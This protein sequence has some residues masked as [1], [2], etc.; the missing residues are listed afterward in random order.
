MNSSFKKR[1]LSYLGFKGIDDG[2]DDAISKSLKE[3]EKIA[4]FRYLYRVFDEAPEFARAEPY[5]TFLKD[6]DKVILCVTTLGA[7]I[8]RRIKVLAKSDLYLSMVLDACASA[9]LEERADEFEKGIADNLTY[10]FC[11]GYGGS[12]IADIRHIFALVRPERAG[13]TLTSEGYMLPFKSMAGIIGVGGKSKKS[14]GG[15]AMV[16]HC[17][18]LKEGGRCYGSENA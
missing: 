9:Y 6:C 10:R 1:A 13:I 15:C 7:E 2:A 17:R 4:N 11:P 3:I 12:D 8:D 18:F 16:A 5:S 14:C